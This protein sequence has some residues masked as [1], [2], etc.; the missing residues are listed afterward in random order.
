VKTIKEGW[1]DR[2][3]AC[4]ARSTAL[5]DEIY[6]RE[7]V[8]MLKQVGMGVVTDPHT[9]PLHV[10]ARDLLDAGINVALGQDDVNDAYYPYG[11]CKM[12]EVAFLASHLLWMMT[13]KDRETLYE[14]ITINPAKMLHV[15]DYGL[16]V[17]DTPTNEFVGF[18]S[19]SRLFMAH[20]R[21]EFWGLP[22]GP[23]SHG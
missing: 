6:H 22:I 3:V 9:G 5:Y 23:L 13:P 20:T 1:I 10:R 2:V 21:L 7:L 15:K 19:H 4:H 11:R 18:S 12:L 16:T 8:A 14:M 17:V